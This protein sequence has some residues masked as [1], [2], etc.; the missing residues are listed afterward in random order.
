VSVDIRHQVL[1]DLTRIG[2]PDESG[3]IHSLE[4][5]IKIRRAEEMEQLMRV[6]GRKFILRLVMDIYH[7]TAEQSILLSPPV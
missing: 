3:I 1:H 5:S 2:I 4:L 6:Q 7:G